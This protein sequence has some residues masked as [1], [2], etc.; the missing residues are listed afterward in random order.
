MGSQ[1][2]PYVCLPAR[3]VCLPAG[4]EC[5]PTPPPPRPVEHNLSATTV[6][7]SNE[8]EGYSSAPPPFRLHLK[9]ICREAIRKHLLNL[10]PHTHLFG[11]VP[12]LGLP[13]TNTSDNF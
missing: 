3:G 9:H 2:L 7:E 11:R 5:L 8:K 4:G 12:R 10:D 1:S 6:A 13:T